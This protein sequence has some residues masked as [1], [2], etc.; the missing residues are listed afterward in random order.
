MF[1]EVIIKVLNDFYGDMQDVDD[2][3]NCMLNLVISEVFQ[4]QEDQLSTQDKRNQ[5]STCFEFVIPEGTYE[6]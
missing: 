1:A 4:T 3:N 5:Q 6:E 2:Q